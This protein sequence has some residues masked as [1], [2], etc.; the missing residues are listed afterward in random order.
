MTTKILGVVFTS[1]LFAG[2]L[3]FAQDTTQTQTGQQNPYATGQQTQTGQQSGAMG[4]QNPYATGQQGQTRQIT[5]TVTS[6]KPNNEITVQSSNGQ[7]HKFS[8]S[9]GAN[10]TVSPDVTKGSTVT[11]TESTGPNGERVTTIT[12]AAGQGTTGG[13]ASGTGTGY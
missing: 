5:G 6:L 13:G 12:P 2:A 8:L 10:T 4:Q 9:T 3:A 7:K 11:V 1:A